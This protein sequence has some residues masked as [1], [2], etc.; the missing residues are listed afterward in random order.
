MKRI[1]LIG[2]ILLAVVSVFLLRGKPAPEPVEPVWK[3][4]LNGTLP[5]ELSKLPG[6]DHAVD[7]FIT[8][9]GIRGASPSR[10][11]IPFSTRGDTEWP[12]NRRR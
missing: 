3:T 2:A 8:F 12:M 5:N 6:L 1:L 9:W 10:G 7:S 4:D 11:T